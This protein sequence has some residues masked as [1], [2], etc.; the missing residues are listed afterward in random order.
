[1]F[2]VTNAR[3][4]PGLKNRPVLRKLMDR[5]FVNEMVKFNNIL[6]YLH[7]CLEILNEVF[8]FQYDCDFLFHLLKQIMQCFIHTDSITY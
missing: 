8:E 1:M 4:M 6:G 3:M 2:K 5:L 7:L